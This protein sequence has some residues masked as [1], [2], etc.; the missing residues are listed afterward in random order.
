MSLIVASGLEKRYGD[1]IVFDQLDF[2]IEQKDRIGLVGP[3]GSGKSS[4]LRIMARQDEMFEGRLQSRQGLT[5]GYLEQEP[6]GADRR[7]VFALLDTAFADVHALGRELDQLTLAI[8]T[9]ADEGQRQALITRYGRMQEEYQERGGYDT[10][11]SIEETLVNLRI[12]RQAWQEPV[13]RLSGGQR[14][15]VHLGYLIL[16]RP[17]LLLLDEPTNYLDV[18]SMPWL[19]R[20]LQNWPGS[21]V[22]VSHDGHFLDRVTNRIWEMNHHRLEIYRGSYAHY[23]E[24]RAARKARQEKE[25]Q[26]QQAYVAKTEEFVRRFKAGQ[27]SKEARGRETRMRRHLERHG[28]DRPEKDKIWKLG[29]PCTRRSGEIVVRTSGLVVGYQVDRPVMQVPD[30]EIRRTATVAVLGPNGTGKSTLLRTIVGQIRALAGT[31]TLGANVRIGYF[32]QHQVKDDYATVDASRSPFDLIQDQ[33]PLQD[34]EVRDHLGMFQLQG[35]DVFRPLSTLS[36]GQKSRLMFA[37]LALADTNFLILDEPM[38]HFDSFEVLQAALK[39][40]AGTILM[41]THDRTL[42]DALAT[43]LWFV[44]AEDDGPA[45]LVVRHETWQAYQQRVADGFTDW[46]DA[47]GSGGGLPKAGDPATPDPDSRQEMTRPS[48]HQIQRLEKEIEKLEQKVGQV[49]DRLAEASARNDS[50]AIRKLRKAHRFL[51]DQT[52]RK[53][54]EWEMMHTAWENQDRAELLG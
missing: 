42:V 24:Q 22:L 41:V 43:E 37:K 13:A 35:E 27:R 45:Q 18:A 47:Q 33:K 11:R 49:L 8:E 21:I 28:I 17:Q 7:T 54:D 29:F 50:E 14:T 3:N 32:A 1:Q 15:R 4:L 6:L 30:L 26:A 38:S 46:D 51:Q 12:P 25:Y 44:A 39:Q 2:R 19:E 9:C 16:Q 52:D 23:R 53:W 31:V 40:Y 36:G 20:T 5:L 48:A 34:Q 10:D